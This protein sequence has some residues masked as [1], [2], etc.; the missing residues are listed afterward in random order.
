MDGRGPDAP[1]RL[2]G[3]GSHGLMRIPQYYEAVQTGEVLLGD[4]PVVKR[5]GPCTTLIDAKMNFGQVVAHQAMTLVH[6]NGLRRTA[7]PA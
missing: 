6:R 2:G 7:S 3:H 1:P 5:T 4:E